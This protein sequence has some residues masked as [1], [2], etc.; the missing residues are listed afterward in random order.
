MAFHVQVQ[1]EDWAGGLRSGW[2]PAF[3]GTLNQTGASAEEASRFDS[4][5]EARACVD[6]VTEQHPDAARIVDD[7]G[8]AY[9]EWTAQARGRA[10]V[11][12]RD[13]AGDVVAVRT[14]V[15]RRTQGTSDLG[16]VFGTLRV[17]A[18]VYAPCKGLTAGLRGTVAEID[19]DGDGWRVWVDFGA[20]EPQLIA[21]AATA[22]ALAEP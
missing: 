10:E 2:R 15:R 6:D 17:G 19:H 22:C 7:E 1:C 11:V 4:Y 5:D 3:D 18:S 14:L 12:E 20:S 21:Y 8:R 16:T 13:A 9:W